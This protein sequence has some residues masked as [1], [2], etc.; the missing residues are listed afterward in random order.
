MNYINRKIYIKIILL[1]FLIAILFNIT[2]SRLFATPEEDATQNFVEGDYKTALIEYQKVLENTQD[3]PVELFLNIA[4]TYYRLGMY[5]TALDFYN[6]AIN[7]LM[8]VSEGTSAL[9]AQ[10]YH[11]IGNTYV[12]IQ[13]REKAIVYYKESL[14]IYPFEYN[15]KYNYTLILQTPP[16]KP[17][18]NKGQSQNNEENNSDGK[19]PENKNENNNENKKE[20]ENKNNDDENKDKNNTPKNLMSNEKDLNKKLTDEDM[21]YLEA[22]AY[23]ENKKKQKIMAQVQKAGKTEYEKDW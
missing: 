16:P 5:N 23:E 7:E 4:N 15:T 3:P 8:P 9:L 12:K 6:K 17:Q 11:N 19:I 18:D 1:T 21:Q 13:N 14:R 10:T 20:N 22:L 2:D